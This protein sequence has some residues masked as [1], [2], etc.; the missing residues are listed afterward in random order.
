MKLTEIKNRSDIGAYLN[1]NSLLGVGAEIGCAY[2]GH[3]RS[4]LSQ[5]KGGKLLMIDPYTKQDPAVYREKTNDTGPFDAWYAEIVQFSKEDTRAVPMRMFSLEAAAIT[6]TE[7]LD[8][9]YIDGNHEFNAVHS[10][11]EA[12]APKI[13]K[14]GLLCGHDFY[15]ATTD[16]HYCQV[17]DAVNLWA[18]ENRYTVHVTPSCSSWWIKKA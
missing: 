10:D 9:V 11:I 1:A 18:K 16:G 13:K 17:E 3:A 14:G 12:W 2:G 4:I 7:S 6:S 8:F 5:W 15:N